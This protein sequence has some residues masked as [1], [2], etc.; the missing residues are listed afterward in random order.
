[1]MPERLSSARPQTGLP[2]PIRAPGNHRFFAPALIAAKPVEPCDGGI[3]QALN[4]LL[5][6]QQI[7]RACRT[8]KPALNR[9]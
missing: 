5:F 1:M 4:L 9:L 8:R 6:L 3:F 7:R 2:P